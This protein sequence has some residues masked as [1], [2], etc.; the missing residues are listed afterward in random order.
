MDDLNK[1]TQNSP[2]PRSERSRIACIRSEQ[3]KTIRLAFQGVEGP[4]RAPLVRLGG[5]PDETGQNQ[6]HRVHHEVSFSAFYA[7]PGIKSTDPPFSVVFTDWLSTTAMLGSASRPAATRTCRDSNLPPKPVVESI[8]RSVNSPSAITGPNCGGV[9]EIGRKISP[10]ASGAHQ[11]QNSVDDFT[12]INCLGASGRLRSEKRRDVRPLLVG[13]VG[14]I[15]ASHYRASQGKKAKYR[16]MTPR[17][18]F[19]SLL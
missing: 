16:R 8:E 15:A 5:G 1:T 9:G 4:Y 3:P 12:P 18:R 19:S 2:C 13:Q 11:V 17:T 14:R 7:F 10:L 6:S